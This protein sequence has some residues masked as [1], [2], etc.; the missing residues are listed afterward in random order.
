MTRTLK[1]DPQLGVTVVYSLLLHLTVFGIIY[2]F[3]NM[4]RPLH[5]V[6]QTYYVDLVNLPVAHPQ[7][8]S[9]SVAEKSSTAS[10]TQKN[11]TPTRQEMRLPAKPL[12][13]TSAP[14]KSPSTKKVQPDV[15]PTETGEEFSKRLAKLE[16][17]VEE[18]H[19]RSALDAIR[20]KA[21]GG[22]AGMPGAKGN[23][24]GSDYA[25]Y[26]RS[27]LEDAFYTP[28]A[29]KGKRQEVRLLLK[30]SRFGK[31]DYRIERSSHDVLFEAAVRRA[32]DTARENLR[33]PPG[34][35]DF[36][37]GFTFR[38]EGVRKK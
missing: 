8:G 28:T 12:K 19:A 21:E 11:S 4:L 29:Y 23:E 24:A 33:P 13:K 6:E 2:Q 20:K 27:R 37:Q 26:V 5:R 17:G 14:L 22:K 30:I 31:I 38:P 10:V 1:K 9:P 36:E 32:I 18:K 3:N 34:G 7:S 15:Q 35:D 16:K 25:S